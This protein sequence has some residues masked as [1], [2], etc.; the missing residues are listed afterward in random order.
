M[1]FFSNL[2]LLES[3]IFSLLLAIEMHSFQYFTGLKCIGLYN[4]A[5]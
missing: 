1:R 5:N 2:E 4:D 3:I